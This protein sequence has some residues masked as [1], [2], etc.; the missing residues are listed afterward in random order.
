MWLH[1]LLSCP[2][3]YGEQGQAAHYITHTEKLCG[4]ANSKQLTV[5][6]CQSLSVSQQGNTDRGHDLMVIYS[7]RKLHS[8]ASLEQLG[9]HGRYTDY[10]RYYSNAFCPVRIKSPE[11]KNANAAQI[12]L[13]ALCSQFTT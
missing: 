3:L 11:T 8:S 6:P 2:L 5:A 10:R 7:H 9:G 4:S 1:S 13:H 12:C